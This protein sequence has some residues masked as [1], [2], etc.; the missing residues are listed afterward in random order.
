MTRPVRLVTPL[1][2]AL[3]VAV[4][5]LSARDGGTGAA[6]E[7]PEPSPPTTV[8]ATSLPVEPTSPSTVPGEA[9]TGGDGDASAPPAEWPKV[10]WGTCEVTPGMNPAICDPRVLEICVP[11]TVTRNVLVCTLTP[12]GRAA[13]RATTTTTEPATLPETANGRAVQ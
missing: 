9:T 10:S 1:G 6:T 3:A 12:A 13:A 5:L 4:L 11:S 2:A 7:T 8:P